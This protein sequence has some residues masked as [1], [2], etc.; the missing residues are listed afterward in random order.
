MVRAQVE[1]GTL[2]TIAIAAW[3]T[4]RKPVAKATEGKAI[5]RYVLTCEKFGHRMPY[6]LSAALKATYAS[7][8]EARQAGIDLMSKHRVILA[9]SVEAKVVRVSDDAEASALVTIA[10]PVPETATMTLEVTTHTVKPNPKIESYSVVFW[11]HH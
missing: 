9:L 6:E 1:P 4:A 8:A 11:Y 7:Q 2:G 5:T 10:R 3:P